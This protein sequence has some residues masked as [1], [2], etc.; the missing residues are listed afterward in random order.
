MCGLVKM[1][2]LD[3]GL[4]SLELVKKQGLSCIFM[5]TPREVIFYIFGPSSLIVSRASENV[6]LKIALKF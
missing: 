1:Y 3:S 6:I 4:V 2:V 5:I